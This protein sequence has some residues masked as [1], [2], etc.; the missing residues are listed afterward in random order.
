ML[1]EGEVLAK[2]LR[3]NRRLA[4][5]H[6]RLSNYYSHRGNHPMGMKYSEDAL[7]E[8]RKSEDVELIVPL[9]LGLLSSY[10]GLGCR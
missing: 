9:A 8:A 10:L 4:L 7:E 1:R 5:F 2:E 6:G 3:D